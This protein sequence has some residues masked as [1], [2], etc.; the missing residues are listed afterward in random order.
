MPPTWGPTDSIADEHANSPTEMDVLTVYMR[1]GGPCTPVVDEALCTDW[2]CAGTTGLPS[3]HSV[4]VS[5]S[6]RLPPPLWIVAVLALS[7]V[8]IPRA[9]AANRWVWPI[10][11]PVIRAFDKPETDYSHGHRGIDIGAIRGREVRSPVDGVV[12][13]AGVVAGRPV[14]SIDTADGSIVSV[15]PVESSVVRGDVVRAGDSIGLVA[16]QHDG[17]NAIHLG[18]RV[19]GVYVDPIQ[20]LGAPPRIVVYESWIEAYALG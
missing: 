19:N 20:F 10:V 7:V 2:L 11:G 14:I 6:R 17:M 5:I 9:E 1:I 3:G 13:F 15:E 4:I 16:A 8:S 12:W 18:I